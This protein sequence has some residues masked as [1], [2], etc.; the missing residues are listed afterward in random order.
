MRALR[1]HGME[2]NW[3]ALNETRRSTE[4]TLS[5]GLTLLLQAEADERDEKRFDRLKQNAGFRYQA[6]IEEINMVAT[7]GLDKG[8][9]TALATG[10]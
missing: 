7:R 9:I 2:R 5:E 6:S 10:E 1:L 3:K 4:L 8:M